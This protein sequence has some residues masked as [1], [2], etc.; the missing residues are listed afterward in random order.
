MSHSDRRSG[1]YLRVRWNFSALT[2]AAFSTLF[3]ARSTPKSF[4]RGL[5]NRAAACGVASCN[6]SALWVRKD[7]LQGHG[8]RQHA[9]CMGS[10]AGSGRG[11]RQSHMWLAIPR[12]W[13][14]DGACAS[15]NSGL[16]EQGQACRR[17][18]RRFRAVSFRLSR[19]PR[20]RF[21]RTWVWTQAK[22]PPCPSPFRGRERSR[23]DHRR[24]RQGAIGTGMGAGGEGVVTRVAGAM[25]RS[26]SGRRMAVLMWVVRIMFQAGSCICGVGPWHADNDLFSRYFCS[27]RLQRGRRVLSCGKGA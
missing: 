25:L 10:G 26:G 17:M 23:F 11:R 3:A 6:V 8:M 18:M 16:A 14:L 1:R 19:F 24:R 7:I 15:D 13:L 20:D 9:A 5:V 21:A 4:V 2:V 27:R 22:R 12:L